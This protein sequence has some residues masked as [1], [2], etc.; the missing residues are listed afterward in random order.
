MVQDT[1]NNFLESDVDIPENMIEQLLSKDLKNTK[2]DEIIN[3][4]HTKLFNLNVLLNK[5]RNCLTPAFSVDIEESAP[6]GTNNKDGCIYFI[7]IASRTFLDKE[8]HKHIVWDYIMKIKITQSYSM[9]SYQRDI[10]H[11]LKQYSSI[12]G[13][14]WKRSS[15]I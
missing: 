8:A 14:E 2:V 7:A 6:K 11:Y 12:Q 15:T 3:R 9:E 4:F 10:F 5:L 13:N 1:P